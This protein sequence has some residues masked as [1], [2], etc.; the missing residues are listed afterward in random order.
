[1]RHF[2]AGNETDADVAQH[3]FANRLTAADFHNRANL[4]PRLIQHLLSQFAR[5][6]TLLAHQQAMPGQRRER[7]RFTAGQWMIAMHCHHQR[8]GAQHAAYQT[9][10]FNQL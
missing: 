5:G 10:V 2:M 3:C 9:S 7:Q 1:M 8:I 6:R 4:D